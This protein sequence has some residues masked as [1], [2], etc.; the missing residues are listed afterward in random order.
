MTKLI[1]N[2]VFIPAW[3]I[4][5]NDSKIKKFYILPWLLSI[6][7]LTVLLVY[8]AIYTYVIVFWKKED[9]LLVILKFVHSDYLVEVLITAVI[10]LIVY[11]FLGPIFEWWLIKYIHS[12]DNNKS[13]STSEAFGQWLYRF[14]AL[15]EYNNIF[16]EFK[17]ISILNGYLFTIRFL[18][19]E[20]ISAISYTFIILFILWMLLNILL[21]YSKYVIIIEDKSVFEAIGVSS[22]ITILN[23][24]RTIKLYFLMFFLN[25]RVIF[26]FLIFLSFP[27]II[28]FAIWLITSKVFLLVAI[29]ILSL[30]F[31][32]FIL[33]LWYLTA[34]LEVFK[35]AIWYYAY[36]EWKK[37][38]D[39]V[40]DDDKKNK[41]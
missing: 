26:N 13:M 5:K 19:A 39:D 6:I 14:G 32:I 31:I 40:S 23:P 34:V 18:W 29:T 38:L 36:V 20:F 27:I 1:K 16:S 22:K 15:F 11:F 7:F 41:I 24:K 37:M 2:K 12:K 9:A 8:Q 30:L 25:L 3:N 35:T 10:F 28:V 33:A 4:I 21:S 17:L